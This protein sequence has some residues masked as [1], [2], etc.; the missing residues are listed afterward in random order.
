MLDV[1]QVVGINENCRESEDVYC[2]LRINP[3]YHLKT[4]VEAKKK[5]KTRTASK[6]E[7]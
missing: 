4:R 7:Q 3:T 6:N 5:K 1:S 2:K